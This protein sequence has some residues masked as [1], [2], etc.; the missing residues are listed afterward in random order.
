MRTTFF[1]VRLSTCTSSR[2]TG[3]IRFRLMRQ[4][5][6]NPWAGPARVF[7]RTAPLTG[8]APN[9]DA[10]E[11][12]QVARFHQSVSAFPRGLAFSSTSAL[13][14]LVR[15]LNARA[16]ATAVRTSA[17][18]LVPTIAVEIGRVQV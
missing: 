12:D 9:L 7:P 6:R 11:V 16:A 3:T 14:S 17:S 18:F 15:G 13:R 1:S 4:K 10:F 2:A 8:P 5:G